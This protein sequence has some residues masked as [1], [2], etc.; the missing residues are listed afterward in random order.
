M[1]KLLLIGAALAA[2]TTGATADS[3]LY[4]AVKDARGNTTGYDFSSFKQGFVQEMTVE[5][6]GSK[7]IHNPAQRPVWRITSEPGYV[8]LTYM[9]DPAYTLI[10]KVE[11]KS[12]AADGTAFTDARLFKNNVMIAEGVCGLVPTEGSNAT[13]QPQRRP[14]G[15]VMDF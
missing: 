13:P 5:R 7:L 11:G 15:R 2:L 1:K 12:V 9:L 10:T 8:G 3:N 14:R 4:C 6:N